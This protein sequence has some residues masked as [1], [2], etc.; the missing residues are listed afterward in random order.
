[1]TALHSGLPKARTL[2][3]LSSLLALLVFTSAW[4]DDEER[5]DGVVEDSTQASFEPTYSATLKHLGAN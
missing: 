4:A 2:F 3:A 5:A 1:M